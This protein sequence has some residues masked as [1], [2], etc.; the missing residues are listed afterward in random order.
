MLFPPLLNLLFGHI[1]A[2]DTFLFLVS[3]Q[4][5][6][7]R[8]GEKG[9]NGIQGLIGQQGLT[10]PPGIPGKTGSKGV[11]GASGTPGPP[12]TCSNHVQ[13]DGHHGQRLSDRLN[14]Y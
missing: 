12:G 8:Q 3:F 7:G 13:N 11:K 9:A 4:G 6:E 14:R 5:S 10:G 2:Q 1:R